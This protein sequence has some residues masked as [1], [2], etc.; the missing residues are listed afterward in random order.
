M[1]LYGKRIFPCIPIKSFTPLSS[2]MLC[3]SLYCFVFFFFGNKEVN[4]LA[5]EQPAGVGFSKTKDR[6]AEWNDAR[7]GENLLAAIKDFLSEFKLTGREFFV[8]GES[9]AGVYIPTLAT[10]ILNDKSIFSLF[11]EIMIF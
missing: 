11:R 6:K 5:I 10:F 4:L 9:Y 3:W 2:T 1:I 8:S 7:M